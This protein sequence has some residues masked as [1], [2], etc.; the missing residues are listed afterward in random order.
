MRGLESKGVMVTGGASGIGA[1][2]AA[3]FLKEGARVCILDRDPKGV[4]KILRGL[5][6]LAGSL[7]CDVP[8]L[9]NVQEPFART[10]EILGGVDLPTRVNENCVTGGRR[11][12]RRT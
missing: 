7:E 1:A 12:I 6:E 2:T 4:E 11:Q 10:V 8:D 5:S 3:R 9:V